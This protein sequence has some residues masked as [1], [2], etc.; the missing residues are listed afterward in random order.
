MVW[1]CFKVG[2]LGT[3]WKKNL[4]KERK[5]IYIKRQPLQ[6]ETV[7]GQWG[8]IIGIRFPNSFIM[9]YEDPMGKKLFLKTNYII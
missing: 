4:S 8:K 9:L 7:L 2:R 3:T 6:L 1:P 5:S